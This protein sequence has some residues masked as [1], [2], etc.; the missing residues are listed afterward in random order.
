MVEKLKRNATRR[1]LLQST[2]DALFHARIDMDDIPALAHLFF[3][4]Q[5]QVVKNPLEG[6][7][8]DPKEKRHHDNKAEH[9]QCHLR[10]FLTGRPY[11]PTGFRPGVLGKRKKATARTGI[12]SN[13]PTQ[14]ETFQIE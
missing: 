13:H 2:P 10:G 3:P 12:P 14:D 6:L 11:D 9:G 8:N 7:V 5:E 4:T 1:A